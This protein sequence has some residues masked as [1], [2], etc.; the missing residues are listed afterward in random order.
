VEIGK[1]ALFEA[2]VEN[3]LALKTQILFILETK[4]CTKE[5]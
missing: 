1:A 4:L 3:K 5:G 2:P